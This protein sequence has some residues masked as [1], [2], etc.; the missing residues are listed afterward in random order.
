[1][2]WSLIKR[3]PWIQLLRESVVTL[4]PDLLQQH[5]R[6]NTTVEPWIDAPFGR[7]LRLKRRKLGPRESFDMWLPTRRAD[8]RTLVGMANKL[9]K[10]S[11]GQ[12][13][14]GETRF[15]FLDKNLVEFI[16]AIPADQLLR[17]GERRSLMRRALVGY[18]PEDI[19]TRRTKSMPSRMPILVIENSWHEL[20][21]KFASS[22]CSQLGYINN[23]CFLESLNSIRHGNASHAAS[24]LRTIALECWLRDLVSR[25]LINVSTN[26]PTST[27]IN[28]SELTFAT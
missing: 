16:L 19:R 21:I 7:R 8:I 5:L 18:L 28:P 24:V 27:E 6:S 15:P 11:A 22:V 10:R 13:T 26:L 20:Q 3:R 2:A 14:L 23:A 1:M 17:P 25:R 9:A 12:L 4:L